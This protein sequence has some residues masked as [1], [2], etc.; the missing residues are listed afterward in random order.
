MAIRIF[1]IRLFTRKFG[2]SHA[3]YNNSFITLTQSKPIVYMRILQIVC[4]CAPLGLVC[5]DF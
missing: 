1:L 5:W 4:F 3:T 2:Y